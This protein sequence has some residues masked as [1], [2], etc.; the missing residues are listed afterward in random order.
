MGGA[1]TEGWEKYLNLSFTGSPFGRERRIFY[2]TIPER[3]TNNHK[4]PWIGKGYL[5]IIGRDAIPAIA[6]WNDPLNFQ[7]YS[8]TLSDGATM[9]TIQADY[10][11]IA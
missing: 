8:L 5:R 10:T 4:A 1:G 2:R 11:V 3:Y 6:G 7:S 9:A